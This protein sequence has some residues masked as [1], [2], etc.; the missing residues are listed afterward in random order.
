MSQ[1]QAS[2]LSTSTQA[3]YHRAEHAVSSSRGKYGSCGGMLG[4]IQ[5]STDPPHLHLHMFHPG[6]NHGLRYVMGATSD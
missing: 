4:S 6:R 2:N 1:A 3:L 5:R